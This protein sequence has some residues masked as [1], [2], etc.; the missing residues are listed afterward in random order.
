MQA[1][2][3]LIGAAETV[4]AVMCMWQKVDFPW[5][6][7]TRQ[8]HVQSMQARLVCVMKAVCCLLQE[9]VCESAA[10]LGGSSCRSRHR[11]HMARQIQVTVCSCSQEMINVLWQETRPVHSGLHSLWID[12]SNQRSAVSKARAPRCCFTLQFVGLLSLSAH[13]RS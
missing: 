9:R 10:G 13:L 7:V 6:I 12:T 8:I 3:K 4:Q 1:I 5:S 11:H 2:A